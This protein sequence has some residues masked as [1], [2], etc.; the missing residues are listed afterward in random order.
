[1]AGRPIT[2]EYNS[3]VTNNEKQMRAMAVEMATKGNKVPEPPDWL[4]PVAAAEY[5][6][7]A[8]T[9]ELLDI[10]MALLCDYCILYE[11]VRALA[12]EMTYRPDD[13]KLVRVFNDTSSK[14]RSV[15]N[16]LGMSPQARLKIAVKRV[17]EA[18]S[19]DPFKKLMM[20][21]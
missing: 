15:A 3:N 4:N 9:L 19:D 2:P 11:R 10:D 12:D 7:V 17:D 5:K 13:L 6:R 20:G 8:G 16:D 14:L 18:R 21:T 1:M